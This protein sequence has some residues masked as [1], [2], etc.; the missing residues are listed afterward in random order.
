MIKGIFGKWFRYGMG[1]GVVD[2]S[3]AIGISLITNITQ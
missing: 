2:Q 3:G 1:W